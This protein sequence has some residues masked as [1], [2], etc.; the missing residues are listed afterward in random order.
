MVSL[1]IE[2][3]LLLLVGY[4]LGKRGMLNVKTREQLTDIVVYIILPCSILKSFEMDL[5]AEVLQATFQIILAAFGIQLIYW[6][7]NGLLYRRFSKDEQIACKYSTMVTNASFIGMP[8]ASAL[9]G[10]TG[11][12]YA[13]VFVIPQRIFMWA[14]G[15]PMYTSVDKKDI[16]KKIVTHPCVFSIFIGLVIMILYSNGI[17][18][19]EAISKT[20]GA[21]GGCTTAL[22]MLVI[23]SVLCDLPPREMICLRSLIF[24]FYRLIF[25]PILLMC[26][27][28]FTPLDTL[29]RRICILMS[30]MPAP[31]TTVILAQKY[32]RDPEFASKL[33]VTSTLLSLITI[34]LVISLID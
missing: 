9:Y 5:S 8:I 2:L 23:G 14:Y 6:L 34:P 15:L 1:Q 11:L 19:P 18:L 25:I 27:L 7:L 33:M 10:P 16:I 31:T 3:F 4:L 32:N 30:A 26:I 12:L 22:C 29:S 17:Y 21:L 13:S 28:K 24:S 20:L